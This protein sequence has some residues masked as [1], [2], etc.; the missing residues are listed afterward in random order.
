MPIRRRVAR[1]NLAAALPDLS[2]PE[3]ERIVAGMY[4]H[5]GASFVE[6]LRFGGQD[7]ADLGSGLRVEGRAHLEA[8]L[9][10]GRGVLVLAA[11]LGNWELLVRAG[12]L[13]GTPVSVVTKSLHSNVAQRAWRALRDGGPT[14]L[15]ARDSARSIVAALQR[16]EVVGFVLDQH[17]PGGVQV[18]FFGRP[19]ATSQG[20]ARLARLT[21]APV[22]PVFS[23]R[24][25]GAHG[26]RIEPPVPWPESGDLTEATGR[27]TARIEVAVRRHPE[28]WLW[29]HRR[30]KT[31]KR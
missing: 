28:Q 4:R 29:I 11:H 21:G 13:C 18:P 5:L 20:L 24:E 31:P 23:W 6:L 17:Q 7:P 22:V 15:P 27:Y 19:A 14:L 3:R 2:E 25:A 9:A 10:Q 26:V 16:N 1:R 30:W 12:T 8:A